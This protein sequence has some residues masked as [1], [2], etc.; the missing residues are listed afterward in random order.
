MI[1]PDQAWFW[2]ERWQRMEQEA[3]AD[4]EAGSLPKDQNA[5]QVRLTLPAGLNPYGFNYRFLNHGI[6][7][8]LRLLCPKR[9]DR[10]GFE[11][12]GG[13]L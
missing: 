11:C 8:S 3:Q 1:P 12:G 13:F 2:T 7:R 6:V 10:V 4:I 9:A 5:L